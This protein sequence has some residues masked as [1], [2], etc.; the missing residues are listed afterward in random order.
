MSDGES[1]WKRELTGRK[2]TFWIFWWGIHWGLFAYG[3]Y[4]QITNA[5]LAGLNTLLYSVWLSRGAGL[6]L[7]FDGGLILLPM[8]RNL[9]RFLRPKITIIPLDESQWLHR[10]TAYA[11]LLFTIIHTTAHYVNFFNV[12]KTQIRPTTALNIHY[13]DAG[14]IT[15]HI[16]LLCMVLMFTTAHSKIRHQCFEAFWYTHHLFIIFMLGFYTHATGCFVRDDAL[17]HSPFAGK[18]FWGHCIGYQAW[19]ITI[20]PGIIYMFERLY[21]ELR[22][23]K[24]T[25]ITKVVRHPYNA[26]EIQFKKPSMSYKSGQWLFLQVPAISAYQWHP[27]T[28]TSCP[29]DPYI[30]VHIRQVGDFTKALAEV[31]G[32]NNDDAYK[33]MD[34]MGVYEVAVQN[35]MTLPKLR[36]DGPYGAPAE[37]VFNNEIAVLVGTGIG[38]TPWASI[39]KNIWHRR[40]SAGRTPMR[41]RRVEFIWV[42]RDMSSFEWFQ[43]LLQSLERQQ[44]GHGGDFLRI[45]TYLTQKLDIDTAQNIVLNSVGQEVDP[46]TQLRTGTQFGRPDFE[47]LFTA[48]RE[49]I[50]NQTYIGG[51]DASLRTNVGVYFCGP[52][53]AAR[54]IKKSCKK[55]STDEVR[56]SFWKEH[57]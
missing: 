55:V 7:A 40:N 54:N 53:A 13:R 50:L 22:A 42:C 20:V 33:G 46:L 41:L 10:Q 37:D 18:E 24:E 30:S 21:R 14:G 43:T 44:N 6:V 27:F 32:I 2:L 15:G 9:L 35:G 28:I 29:S 47:K 39:L 25:E 19:R 11:M 56:F 8:C 17:P 31:L 12:E 36:I 23:R 38:V 26:M 3:W 4:S 5:R 49:G 34:P 57:F 48:L 1:F 16:M 45:H 51:L 52:S